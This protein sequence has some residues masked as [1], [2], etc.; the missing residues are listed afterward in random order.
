M[1][2]PD[3]STF[4][5]SMFTNFSCGKAFTWQGLRLVLTLSQTKILDSF[6][7]KLFAEDNFKLDVNG[8]KFSKLV[9]NTVEKRRNYSL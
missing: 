8:R 5:L 3:V 4:N 9:E 1:N 2:F 6:K 7:L